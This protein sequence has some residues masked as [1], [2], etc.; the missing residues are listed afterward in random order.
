MP[1]YK[2]KLRKSA[3]FHVFLQ[4]N[5]EILLVQDIFRR[6]NLVHWIGKVKFYTTTN[7][8]EWWTIPLTWHYFTRLL[9]GNRY[10]GIESSHIFYLLNLHQPNIPIS[11]NF[12]FLFFQL[13]IQ[14][15]R[16]LNLTKNWHWASGLG[17][18]GKVIF[19]NCSYLLIQVD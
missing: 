6:V 17:Q 13:Q 1:I 18:I 19:F 9:G 7:L 8:C 2:I 15:V 3:K 16:T 14:Q 12:F 10:L 11:S 5:S 4:S